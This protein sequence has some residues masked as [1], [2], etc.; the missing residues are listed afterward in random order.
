MTRSPTRD[1]LVGVFVLAGLIAIGYLSVSIGGLNYSGPGG[2]TLYAQF[3]QT[4]GLKPRA[5][6]VISGVKVGQVKAI[7]LNDDFRARVEIDVD[8]S[9]KL[10]VDTSASIVTAGLL[11][12][13]Y[14]SLEVGGE[15]QILQPGDEIG[16]TESAVILERLIGKFIHDAGVGNGKEGEQRE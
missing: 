2:L 4:G 15:E 7:A 5:P 16:F 8:R 13:R 6:V 12:D 14:I 3:D 1:F 10:P 11:G 9:L